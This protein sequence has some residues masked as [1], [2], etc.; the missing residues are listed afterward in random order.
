VREAKEFLVSRIIAEAR[1]EN[2]PLSDV[3]TKM[4]YF[5]ETGWTLPDMAAANE[6]FDRDYEQEAYEGKIATLIRNLYAN[7]RTNNREELDSWNG[8]VRT[9]ATEDHYLLVLIDR[10]KAAGRP[11]GDLLKLIG[12]GLAILCVLLAVFFLANRT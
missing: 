5:S 9:I 1:R 10:A 8:A 2:V 3:E 12:V 7:A 11:R 6:A 4:L